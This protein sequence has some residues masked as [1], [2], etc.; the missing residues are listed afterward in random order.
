MEKQEMGQRQQIFIGGEGLKPAMWESQIAPKRVGDLSL[1]LQTFPN[2]P[3]HPPVLVP[4]NEYA[5]NATVDTPDKRYMMEMQ[6][7]ADEYDRFRQQQGAARIVRICGVTIEEGE[8]RTVEEEINGEQ[9]KCKTNDAVFRA[10]ETAKPINGEYCSI[11]FSGVGMFFTRVQIEDLPEDTRR[12]YMDTLNAVLKAKSESALV[13]QDDRKE[14]GKL[15]IYGDYQEAWVANQRFD[16]R[17]ADIVRAM[18]RCLCESGAVG[19]EKAVQKNK[20]RESI[21]SQV[22]GFGPVDFRPSAYLRDHL[23]GLRDALGKI[24]NKGL[25]WIKD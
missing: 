1:S 24:D 10:D 12:A 14:F 9:V 6:L 7:S 13:K 20:I 3:D 18:V 5:C 23:G 25:Y 15:T 8:I 4:A 22:P 16:L 21:Q 2:G 19:R 17:E 11:E